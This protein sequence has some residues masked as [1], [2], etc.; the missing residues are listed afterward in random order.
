FIERSEIETVY[1]AGYWTSHFEPHGFL[2]DDV[3]MSRSA[4]NSARVARDAFERTISA[5][6]EAGKHLV[7]VRNVPVLD[8]GGPSCEL[9]NRIHPAWTRRECRLPID[10]FHAKTA[11]VDALFSELLVRHPDLEILEVS[12]LLCADGFCEIM[13]DDI[14]LYKWGDRNHLNMAGSRALGRAYLERHGRL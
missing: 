14:S 8:S 1:I 13:L 11:A 4:E 3:D 6:R 10:K 2:G 9:K 7:I 12:D 5:V